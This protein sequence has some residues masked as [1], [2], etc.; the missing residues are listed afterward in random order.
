VPD[1]PATSDVTTLLQA[2]NADTPGA[3]DRLLDLVYDELRRMAAA[4]LARQQ[5]DAVHQATE[6][7]HDAFLKLFGSAPATWNDRAHMFGAAARAMD[8]L[9]VDWARRARRAK[10]GGGWRRVPMEDLAAHLDRDPHE[11]IAVSEAIG[12][13]EIVDGRKATVVRLRIFGGLSRAEIA[14]ALGVSDG[15]VK[16]DWKFA[17]AW[18]HRELS[19]S[20]TPVHLELDPKP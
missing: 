16:G 1:D 15:T 20:G 12:K 3:L 6:L 14:E 8:Q 17:R 10:R 19:E 4:K 18:L 7:V 5:H 13:L 11:I 9:I 2:V